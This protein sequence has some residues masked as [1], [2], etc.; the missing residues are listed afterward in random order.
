M[1][2]L[3]IED[4]GC[5]IDAKNLENVFEPYYKAD[6]SRNSKVEG[7]GLGLSIVKEIVTK[8]NGTINIKSTP[9][10]GTRIEILL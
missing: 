9:E 1:L 2:Q 10:K 3:I 6:K 7:W 5:G 4:Y 8:H